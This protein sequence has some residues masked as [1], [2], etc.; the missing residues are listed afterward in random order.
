MSQPDSAA[1]GSPVNRVWGADPLYHRR[2]LLSKPKP[3]FERDGRSLLREEQALVSQHY[4]GLAFRADAKSERMCLE[5]EL[6]LK[7]D[8]GISTSIFIRIDFPD[9]YPEGEPTAYDAAG[10]FVPS[11]DRHILKDGQFCLWLP[12]CSPWSKDNPCRLLRFLDE[13]TVFLERQLVYDAINGQLWPGPQFKHGVDGY[14]EFMLL[15]LG[16]NEEH[17]RCLFPVIVGC[18]HAGRNELCPCGSKLKYKRC[19]ADRV[20]EITRRVGRNRLQFLYGKSR[21]GGCHTTKL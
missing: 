15:I 16:G 14:D 12:P 8:C 11:L 2:H 3:W 1:L 6:I 20:E 4:P 13:V 7:A 18:V 9:N 21:I 5:G 10:R 17:L 19:H